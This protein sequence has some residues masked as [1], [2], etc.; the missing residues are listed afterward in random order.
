MI[1]IL[2]ALGWSGAGS[3]TVTTAAELWH[4]GI[5]LALTGAVAWL[6]EASQRAR[7]RHRQEEA[8]ASDPVPGVH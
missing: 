2:M 7:V 1:S 5:A 8:A 6:A 4:L 3:G